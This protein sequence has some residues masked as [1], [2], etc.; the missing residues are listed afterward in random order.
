MLCVRRSKTVEQMVSEV[1]SQA[2]GDV[3]PLT[4]VSSTILAKVIEYCK[5]QLQETPR[6]SD[7][8]EA[9]ADDAA[10]E[11]AE[12]EDFDIDGDSSRKKKANK[13]TPFEQEF[14]SVEQP[15]LFDLMLVS[16]SFPFLFRRSFDSAE[17]RPL[18]VKLNCVWMQGTLL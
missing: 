9:E 5:H 12:E 2:A 18:W 4:N 13:L 1:E 8:L 10:D 3:I 7:F 15:V 6:T 17:T 11:D 14:I 16:G